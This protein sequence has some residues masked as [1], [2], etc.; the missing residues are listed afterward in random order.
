ML[1]T[2]F[3]FWLC[4]LVV[5]AQTSDGVK[6]LGNPTPGH[7]L[8]GQ[9]YNASMVFLDGE[10]LKMSPEGVFIFGYD[11]DDSG[12]N[13]L[14]VVYNDGTTENLELVLNEREYQIQRINNLEHRH[15]TPPPDVL[16]RIAKER[17]II[18]EARKQI[19]TTQT[20][21]FKSGFM[22]PVEGGRIS[23]V[24]GSQ[25]IL[26][27]E[28][29][30]P[31]NGVDIA[32]PTGTPVYAMADGIVCLRGDDFYYNGNFVLLDHG[33]GLN[34][35][36]VHLHKIHVNDGDFVRKGEKIG[37]VGS[38]GR[39]TGPHLHWGVQWY[40]KRIDPLTILELDVK[41]ITKP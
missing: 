20:P 30:N 31:H 1:R 5:S 8:V 26:N 29:R 11:R 28:P 38:T 18:Q 37:E 35:V 13:I 2:L 4:P 15:V 40:R 9:A 3:F 7:L 39:S 16:E 41:T 17:Q 19:D 24:F 27:N 10:P 12:Q 6:L 36:Y 14:K 21:Y 32:L 33:L 23:G 34:S 25:R 22:R